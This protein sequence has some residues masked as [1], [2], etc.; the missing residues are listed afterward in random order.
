MLVYTL[1]AI[2]AVWALGA[3]VLFVLLVRGL[4]GRSVPLSFVFT[5]IFWWV[6]G[7]LYMLS[8]KKTTED[9]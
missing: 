7:I 8:D 6:W 2:A 4:K 5:S 3:L 1:E 9:I